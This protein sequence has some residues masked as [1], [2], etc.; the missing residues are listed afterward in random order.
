MTKEEALN[1][2]V[3]NGWDTKEAESHIE[4][5]LNNSLL[6]LDVIIRMTLDLQTRIQT[7]AA[8][9]RASY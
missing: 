8:K 1:L 9:R 3:S 7:Y 2:L 4:D 6:P 5:N